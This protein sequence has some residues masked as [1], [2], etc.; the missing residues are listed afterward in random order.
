MEV[1]G[2]LHALIK[3]YCV[4]KICYELDITGSAVFNFNISAVD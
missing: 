2:Q 3:M 4:S 1:S